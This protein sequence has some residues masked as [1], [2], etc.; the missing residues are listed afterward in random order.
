[1]V[2]IKDFD[3]SVRTRAT[4]T[5]KYETVFDGQIHKLVQGDELFPEDKTAAQVV[6]SMRQAA[7]NKGHKLQ[8]RTPED[9]SIVVKA[10]DVTPKAEPKAEKSVS[11]GK[12]SKKK[13]K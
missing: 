7:R 9:G 5:S 11:K 2:V 4:R 12:T 3:F 13:G 6:A 10:V 1:M 8:V